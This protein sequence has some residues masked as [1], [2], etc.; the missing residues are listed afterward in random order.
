MHPFCGAKRMHFTLSVVEG[1]R[2][3]QSGYCLTFPIVLIA[4]CNMLKIRLKRVGR[5]HDPSFR[6]VL[7]ESTNGPKS[8]NFLEVLGSYDPRKKESTQ[9]KSDR[10][11]YWVSKGA[12]VSDTVHN[13][14]VNLGVREG[15]KI[16]VLPKKRPIVKEKDAS[17]E[18]APAA[19]TPTP[20]VVN[21]TA[22]ATKTPEAEASSPETEDE[23]SE[24][25]ATEATPEA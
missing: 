18:A 10:I 8:G 25:D 21:E 3:N 4:W 1:S 16:N 6:V 17:A 7:T 5:K 12:Q 15:K 19:E 14:L 22:E 2:T 23:T 11:N 9:V 24:T 20:A 13:A